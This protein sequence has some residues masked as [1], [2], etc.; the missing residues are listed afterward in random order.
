MKYGG[1]VI[2]FFV[3]GIIYALIAIPIAILTEVIRFR[4]PDDFLMVLTIFLYIPMI[5]AL[6]LFIGKKIKRAAS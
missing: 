3:H 6:H 5:F 4:I 1:F 2:A